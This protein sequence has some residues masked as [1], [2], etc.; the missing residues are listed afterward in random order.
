MNTCYKNIYLLLLSHI[1]RDFHPVLRLVNKKWN[2]VIQVK[3]SRP[4]K[5]LSYATTNLLE[6]IKQQPNVVKF[7]NASPFTLLSVLE[8]GIHNRPDLMTWLKSN[9]ETWNCKYFALNGEKLLSKCSHGAIKLDYQKLI[10]IQQSIST[11]APRFWH[12]RANRIIFEL[13]HSKS[14][15]TDRYFTLLC[16]KSEYRTSHTHV[17]F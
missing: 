2:S 7:N 8:A 16:P 14:L 5:L 15:S 10:Y 13:C 4:N 17:T 1:P 6:F 3:F 12:E 11:M 9:S